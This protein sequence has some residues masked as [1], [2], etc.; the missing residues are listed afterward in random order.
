VVATAG[1]G[2]AFLAGLLIGL[3][4][5]SSLREAAA[6]AA[7]S[8][9]AATQTIGAGFIDPALVFQLAGTALLTSAAE[10]FAGEPV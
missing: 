6:L 4:R 7:A 1:A 9:A 10:F 5:G 8:A 2:D 3:R